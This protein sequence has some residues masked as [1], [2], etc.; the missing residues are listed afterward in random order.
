MLLIKMSQK[1]L[2]D[3]KIR[4]N[5][6][7]K[8]S[9]PYA[10]FTWGLHDPSG[11]PDYRPTVGLM[12]IWSNCQFNC[13]RY[14]VAMYGNIIMSNADKKITSFNV[15]WLYVDSI[16]WLGDLICIVGPKVGWT[17]KRCNC[18]FNRLD[19]FDMF[20]S[21]NRSADCSHDT[22][23]GPTGQSNSWIM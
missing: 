11:W 18:W 17:F 21:S 7:E 9:E 15:S 5:I 3:H 14:H 8:M 22:T 10:G 19:E 20:D 12:F 16:G 13:L 2:A 4:K 23:V 6:I 1:L